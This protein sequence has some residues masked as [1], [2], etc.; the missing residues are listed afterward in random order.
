M[1]FERSKAVIGDAQSEVTAYAIKGNR[2][3][4]HLKGDSSFTFEIINRNSMTI[5]VPILGKVRY[6]RIS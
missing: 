1:E 3:T 5:D 4:V 6:T 2:I